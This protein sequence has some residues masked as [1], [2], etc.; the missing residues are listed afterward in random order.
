MLIGITQTFG[1]FGR[2][3]PQHMPNQRKVFAAAHFGLATVA[4]ASRFFGFSA[5]KLAPNFSLFLGGNPQ[6]AQ[7][8][9]KRLANS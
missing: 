7:L 3:K 9:R 6:A 4:L 1:V 5:G 2:L 8:R